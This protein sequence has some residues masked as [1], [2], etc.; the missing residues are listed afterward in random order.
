MYI[1]TNR[2]F[3]MRIDLISAIFLAIVTFSAIPLADSKQL[4]HNIIVV[5]SIET[6]H[7]SSKIYRPGT[8]VTILHS[9]L[10]VLVKLKCASL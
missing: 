9:A 6:L 10:A 2:W 3:G 7:F 4:Y 8:I 5:T 1:A